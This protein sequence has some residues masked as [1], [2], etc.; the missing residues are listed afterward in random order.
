MYNYFIN[1]GE[2]TNHIIIFS[3]EPTKRLPNDFTDAAWNL[4]VRAG[5]LDKDC[6]QVTFYIYDNEETIFYKNS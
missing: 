2:K 1:R 6:S 3:K 4:L 5:I